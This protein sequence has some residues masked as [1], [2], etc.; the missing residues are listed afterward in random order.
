MLHTLLIIAILVYLAPFVLGVLVWLGFIFV[1]EVLAPVGVFIGE[2]CVFIW[3]ILQ[4]ITYP[5]RRFAQ[6]AAK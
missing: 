6:S 2:L 3:W 5:V 4:T 1:D